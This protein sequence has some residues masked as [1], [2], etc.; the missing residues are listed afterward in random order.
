MSIDFKNITQKEFLIFKKNFIDSII[1][2]VTDPSYENFKHSF[3]FKN[4]TFNILK[5]LGSENHIY[6]K[7]FFELNYDLNKNNVQKVFKEELAFKLDY[8][9]I[10][11][12][13]DFP[14]EFIL[15][16]K[17]SIYSKRILTLN[18]IELKKDKYKF[19]VSNKKNI[20]IVSGLHERN[21][22][23]SN[24]VEIHY[25]YPLNDSNLKKSN[26][27]TYRD[28]LTNKNNNLFGS[29]II[30]SII[31]IIKKGELT[32]NNLLNNN[33]F[34]IDKLIDKKEIKNNFYKKEI[35]EVFN[36]K[37]FIRNRKSSN[38]KYKSITKKNFRYILIDYINKFF[39]ENYHFSRYLLENKIKFDFDKELY[40]LI[41]SGLAI[42]TLAY[43][44]GYQ[45]IEGL[46]Y[47]KDLNEAM[48]NYFLIHKNIKKDFSKMIN[49]KK[50]SF[51]TK[52]M[53]LKTNIYYYLSKN[54]ASDYIELIVFIIDKLKEI[55]IS[56]KYIRAF[57]G[58]FLNINNY[59][60]NNNL[61]KHELY[62][63]FSNLL[64]N[65]ESYLKK[66]RTDNDLFK[67]FFKM[68]LNLQ[69]HDESIEKTIEALNHLSTFYNKLKDYKFTSLKVFLADIELLKNKELE[70]NLLVLKDQFNFDQ[71]FLNYVKHMNRYQ[72]VIKE[73]TNIKKS[74]YSDYKEDNYLSEDIILEKNNFKIGIFKHNSNIGILGSNVK[75]VCISSFG[76]ERLSQIN[77]YFL[78]LC[79]YNESNGVFLWGLLCRAED[80]E[81]GEVMYI[82]NNL[83][84][85]NNKH[86]VCNQE[87]LESIYEVMNL[88]K[89]ELKIDYI[90]FKEQGFNS[91]KLKTNNLTYS[92][93]TME[94]CKRVR[95]DFNI[96]DTFYIL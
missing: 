40:S 72:T 81:T 74:V 39:K 48:N 14:E 41:E 52:E 18:D 2:S 92:S 22:I 80:K 78:N 96:R 56:E 47:P 37:L 59:F 70:E 15:D 82:L 64:I 73:F 58:K 87:I 5:Y 19:L 50:Y 3:F 67:H 23:Y 62:F 28:N 77:K 49:P 54:Q 83:Q 43:I 9:L 13:I 35:L 36:K 88:L 57:F 42:Y 79:I 75:G 12:V 29:D 25:E 21:G 71:S 24:T 27:M 16:K 60:Q 8:I 33:S 20:N 76:N 55:N 85:S 63:V 61:N 31:N 89:V 84:G 94:L 44:N 26:K 17:L 45:R 53:L 90:L 65:I 95:L 91:L 1:R 10:K 66:E 4:Q 51:K 46:I 6:L 32:Y 69:I 34:I 93:Q 30:N 68:I 38:V 11:I 7:N 86:N